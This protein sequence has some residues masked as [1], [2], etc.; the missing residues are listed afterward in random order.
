MAIIN[1]GSAGGKDI[2]VAKM[3]S[4]GTDVAFYTFIGGDNDEWGTGIA[5]NSSSGDL[6]V[7]GIIGTQDFDSGLSGDYEPDNPDLT[8]SDAF[9]A[10]VS[11]SGSLSQFTFLGGGNTDQANGV[12]LDG[13]GN[14]CVVGQTHSSDF[15]TPST[16]YDTGSNGASD[17]FVA[18][19]NSSLTTLSYS[20]YLGGSNYD[21]G[22]GHR[23]AG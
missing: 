18:K 14:V 3:N 6:Y 23:S 10:K 21:Y 1:T 17:V 5:R 19:L 12:A 16:P 11:S 4:S 2:F 8:Y 20:T 15:P 22:K 7:V 13:S 9:V